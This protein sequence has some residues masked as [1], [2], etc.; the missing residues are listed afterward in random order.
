MAVAPHIVAQGRRSAERAAMRTAEANVKE[1]AVAPHHNGQHFKYAAGATGFAPPV[2]PHSGGP[3]LVYRGFGYASGQ[4]LTA[5]VGR[6]ACMDRDI[7][8]I[9]VGS[10]GVILF[11][12]ALVVW[13]AFGLLIDRYFISYLS[14]AEVS[15]IF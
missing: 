7:K 1:L 2:L 10:T 8:S 14:I 4:T 6:L 11:S 12:I 9:L 5:A 3:T 15:S 13:P